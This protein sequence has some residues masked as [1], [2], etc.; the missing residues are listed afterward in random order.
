MLLG[1][2]SAVYRVPDDPSQPPAPRFEHEGVCCAAEGRRVAVVAMEGGA[3]A[4]LEGDKTRTLE[5]AVREPIASLLLLAEQPLEV[6][7]GTEEARLYRVLGE[8]PKAERLE[9]FDA[10]PCRSGWHTPWGGPPAVR[11]LAA[12]PDRWVYAD[13]HVGGIMRSPDGGLTWEPV[14][15]D[16]NEDV[17]QV[18]TCPAAPER[19][20][21]NTARAFYLSEDRG[22]SWQ[23]RAADL[24]E[25]YG[26]C[27]AV[28]PARPDLVLVT[29][30]DGPHGDDVHGMLYRTEDAGRSWTHVTGGFPASTAKNIDTYHVA[31]SPAGVAFAVVGPALYASRDCGA[32][33]RRTWKAPESI[34][35]LAA[36][37][38]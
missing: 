38:K 16:L 1:T 9:A 31:F 27:V 21:A 14:T 28:H 25:R 19:V 18:A 26:R 10:L 37:G 13:I 8:R 24:Q 20:Y 15:P 35:M 12:T 30:S 32:T 3:L 36:R 34:R 7:V 29:V 4:V 17:H 2:A 5:A 33:W 11:S 23:H 22:R 6:L